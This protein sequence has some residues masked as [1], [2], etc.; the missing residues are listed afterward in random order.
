[1]EALTAFSV[2]GTI[3]EFS[4]F[5]L[6]LLRDSRE[7]YKSSHGALSGNEQLELATADLRA[8]LVKLKGREGSGT[9]MEEE[10]VPTSFQHILCGAEYTAKE[11]LRRLEGLKIRG[12]KSDK[13]EI[14]RKAIQNHWGKSDIEAL[15]KKLERFKDAVQPHV[16]F[17]I[18]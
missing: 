10:K 17:S 16:L 15:T 18:L 11:L 8:L 6:S 4:R 3:L 14:V 12:D 2:A 13:W 7:L 9:K 5:G 1:M